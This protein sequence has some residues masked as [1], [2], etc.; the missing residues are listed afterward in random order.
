MFKSLE[1][2]EK[3]KYEKESYIIFMGIYYREYKEMDS[4]LLCDSVYCYNGIVI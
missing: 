1:E 4:F 3:I 2:V